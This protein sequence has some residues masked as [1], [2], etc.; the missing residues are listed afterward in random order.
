MAIREADDCLSIMPEIQRL[1]L[2]LI[3]HHGIRWRIKTGDAYSLEG[4]H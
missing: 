4:L 3:D 1:I 2:T